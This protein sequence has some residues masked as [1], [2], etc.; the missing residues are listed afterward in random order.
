MV[1]KS[2]MFLSI[3]GYVKRSRQN[4]LKY[5]TVERYL[6]AIEIVEVSLTKYPA[7]RLCGCI[8]YVNKNYK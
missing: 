5:N 7:N 4:R 6:E 1:L 8:Q 2:E 3:A